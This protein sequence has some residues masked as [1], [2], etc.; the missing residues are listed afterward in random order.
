MSWSVFS[1]ERPSAGPRSQHG[2]RA[3]GRRQG[4]PQR[5]APSSRKA[6]CPSAS[7]EPGLF[8]RGCDPRHAPLS[9]WRVSP[10]P[11]PRAEASVTFRVTRRKSC[12]VNSACCSG[13]CQLPPFHRGCPFFCRES[14]RQMER[15]RSGLQVQGAGRPCSRSYRR[16]GERERSRKKRL[17]W[18]SLLAAPRNRAVE[19]KETVVDA[20]LLLGNPLTLPILI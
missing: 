20:S 4:C 17:N 3:A 10:G 9:A 11:F 18:Q 13:G 6:S 19:T 7:G 14:T 16:G 15:F 5:A 2:R 8:P 12:V 1:L